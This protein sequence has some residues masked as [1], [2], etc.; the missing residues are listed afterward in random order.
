MIRI[1]T[2]VR[3]VRSLLN[4]LNHFYNTIELRRPEE[5]LHITILRSLA[6][7]LMQRNEKKFLE[8]GIAKYS[9]SFSNVSV[10]SLRKCFIYLEP[11][12]ELWPFKIEVDQHYVKLL[13][14]ML[15]EKEFINH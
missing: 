1:K 14:N 15:T 5:L 10:I 11:P 9:I 8:K 4:Y 13:Q 6:I 3:E 2:D 12:V 7:L